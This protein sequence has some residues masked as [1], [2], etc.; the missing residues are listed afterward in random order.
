MSLTRAMA[1]LRVNGYSALPATF[2]PSD[3]IDEQ[4]PHD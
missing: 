1:P 4:L 3:P 2:T